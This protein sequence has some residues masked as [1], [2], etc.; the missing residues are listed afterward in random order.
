MIIMFTKFIRLN[1]CECPIGS[2][3]MLNPINK[4]FDKQIIN[5]VNKDPI[6]NFNCLFTNKPPLKKDCDC[7]SKCSAGQS[8][9]ELYFNI[10]AS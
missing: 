7:V 8:E 6:N 10:F 3:K 4:V 5:D 1:K 2:C 9:L